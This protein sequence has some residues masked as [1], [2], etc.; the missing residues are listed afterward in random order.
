ML[1][2]ISFSP[3]S[4]ILNLQF[5]LFYFKS[6][7][8]FDERSNFR[9]QLQNTPFSFWFVKQPVGWLLTMTYFSI[10]NAF[11]CIVSML[12]NIVIPVTEPKFIPLVT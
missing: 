7:V 12:L 5:I 9:I 3:L 11:A 4:L 1:V 2:H 10:V 6:V 8:C